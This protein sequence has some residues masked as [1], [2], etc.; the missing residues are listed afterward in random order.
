[1][2][3]GKKSQE[4]QIDRRVACSFLA[5]LWFGIGLMLAR[6]GIFYMQGLES[7]VWLFVGGVVLG[8]VKARTVIRKMVIRVYGRM[9][10]RVPVTQVLTLRD[11]GVIVCMMGLGMTLKYWPI[12]DGPR[13]LID[14]AVGIALMHGGILYGR[15][16]FGLEPK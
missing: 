1:M 16:V 2:I 3:N 10:E 8:Q 6:K 11:I 4:M 14:L 5:L 13:G 12:P 9:P 15:G 7:L